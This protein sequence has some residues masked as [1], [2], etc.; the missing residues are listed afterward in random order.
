MKP[1]PGESIADSGLGES[2]SPAATPVRV[3]PICGTRLA[4]SNSTEFCPV[5]VLRCAREGELEFKQDVDRE[6]A[7]ER[8]S[9]RL[10]PL[11][12]AHKFEHYELVT[13]EDGSPV[14]LGRGSMGVTYKAV[15]V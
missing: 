8:D 6:P 5:C 14:E 9:Q 11:S 15:D 12:L 7:R 2:S 10:V 1:E 4:L 13:N 3:C